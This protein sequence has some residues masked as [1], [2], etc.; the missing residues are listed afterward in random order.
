MLPVRVE[1]LEVFKFSGQE[2][3]RGLSTEKDE[4]Q[5][6]KYLVAHK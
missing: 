4:G 2:N 6:A 3:C 5:L 1:K